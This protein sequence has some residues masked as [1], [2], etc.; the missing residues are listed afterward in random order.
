MNHTILIVK[1]NEDPIHLIYC[2][3]EI[4]KIDVQFP[5][6]KK[7]NSNNKIRLILWGEHKNDFLRYYRI[8][9][10]LLI[11]GI[12]TVN[13]SKNYIEVNVK[14]LYPFFVE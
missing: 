2:N 9:D 4:I 1:V 3:Q 8:Q 6:L 7:K 12:I 11:E 10:Y 5:N 13:D 14:K